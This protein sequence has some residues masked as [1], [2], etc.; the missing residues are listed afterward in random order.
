MDLAVVAANRC[1]AVLISSL[2]PLVLKAILIN[3]CPDVDIQPGE[4]GSK[5]GTLAYQV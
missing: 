3:Y 1:H 4:G 2:G 5:E